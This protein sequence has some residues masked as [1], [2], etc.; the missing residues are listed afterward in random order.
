MVSFDYNYQNPSVFCFLMLIRDIVLA[1]SL[2]LQN[3]NLK[4]KNEMNS[5]N[6]SQMT[7]S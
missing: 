2:E 1:F 6:C 4:R 5:G 3:L 7:P